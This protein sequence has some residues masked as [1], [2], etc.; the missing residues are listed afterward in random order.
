MRSFF[1]AV[2]GDAVPVLAAPSTARICVLTH[3]AAVIRSVLTSTALRTTRTKGLAPPWAG[4]AAVGRR[5]ADALS[6]ET[7]RCELKLRLVLRKQSAGSEQQLSLPDRSKFNSVVETARR[8]NDD[9]VAAEEPRLR[10][11]LPHG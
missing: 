8:S 4:G 10:V 11:R 9:R 1:F 6:L 2:C 7:G 3:R 5:L